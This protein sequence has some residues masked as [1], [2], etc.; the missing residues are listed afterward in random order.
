[1]DR[2]GESDTD[3]NYKKIFQNI[4]MTEEHLKKLQKS[5]NT[6][7][8]MNMRSKVLG[9]KYSVVY[10]VKFNPTGKLIVKKLLIRRT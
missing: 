5:W 8:E 10:K 7:Q 9:T 6:A 4:K 2:V 3:I 1:M